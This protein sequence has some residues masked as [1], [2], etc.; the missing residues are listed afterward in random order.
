MPH[1]LFATGGQ[2]SGCHRVRSIP[3]ILRTQAGAGSRSAAATIN[4]NAARLTFS[5]LADQEIIDAVV[6]VPGLGIWS[7]EM[8]LIFSVGRADVFSVGDLALRNGVQR[9]L[10]REM[11]HADIE[12]VARR[13]S[14]YRSIASLYLWKIAHWQK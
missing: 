7:A 5:H 12:D 4:G 14:P 11:T 8:F 10:G 13:W 1:H 6:Q 2:E 3:C 9:V